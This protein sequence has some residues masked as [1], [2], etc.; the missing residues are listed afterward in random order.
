MYSSHIS[1]LA[2]NDLEIIVLFL[3]NKSTTHKR[4]IRNFS[5]LVRSQTTKYENKYY[6]FKR[7]ISHF[8]TNWNLLEYI[9]FCKQYE[10]M[11]YMG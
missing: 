11:R 3:R 6:Y 10:P 2:S 7:W 5:G 4:L 1:E 8:N 9:K